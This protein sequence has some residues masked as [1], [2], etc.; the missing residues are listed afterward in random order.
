MIDEPLFRLT[1]MA[2]LTLV[3]GGAVWAFFKQVRG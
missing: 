2:L 3:A 1:L